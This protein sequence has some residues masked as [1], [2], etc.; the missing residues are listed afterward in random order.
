VWGSSGSDVF[1]V[2]GRML[3]PC[4]I[5][6]YDGVD[7]SIMSHPGGCFS[8]LWGSSGSDVFAVGDDGT[9]LH[10]DG[11]TWSPMS[12]GTPSDLGGVWGSSGS[13]VFA[14][15]EGGTIL[16]YDGTSWSAMSSSTY[17]GLQGVWGS[18][19]GDVTAVGDY[20]TIV[21]YSGPDLTLAKAVQPGMTVLPGEAITFTLTFNYADMVTATGVLITDV[22]PV[23][24]TGVSYHSSR[25]VTPTGTVSYAWLLSDMS[26]GEG[27]VIT[28]TG[29]VSPDLSPGHAFTNTATITAAMV[30][31]N[32][33]NN[34]DSVRVSIQPR[35]FVYL[36]LVVKNR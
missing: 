18:S 25:P 15:G 6:H 9:I 21:H 8:G 4:V 35:T 7:W 16:H 23:E 31:G 27:G 11:V 22:V 29:I 32:L 28:V 19:G 17:Y 24:V 20:G 26:P 13:D 14:V 30:D 33:A 5:V 36:P 3:V 34:R 10:Y 12:S 1:A 2:G